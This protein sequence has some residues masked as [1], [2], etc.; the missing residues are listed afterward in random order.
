MKRYILLL[1]PF[2]IFGQTHPNLQIHFQPGEPIYVYETASPGASPV[3]YSA[4]VQNVAIINTSDEPRIIT[5][6]EFIAYGN[7]HP[8][9][10]K[11]VDASVLRQHAQRL[12]QYEQAGVLELLEFQLQRG[13]YFKKE[14]TL[15][16]SD[17]LAPKQVLILQHQ[18]FLFDQLPDQLQLKVTSR[19]SNAKTFEDVASVGIV[20]HQSDNTY[21]FPV[22]GQ[23]LVA[24]GPSF[25]GHHRWAGIQE[26]AFDLIQLGDGTRSFKN[27]GNQLSDYHCYGLPVRAVADG[28]VVKV[29]DSEAESTIMLKRSDE[30]EN[31]HLQRVM[32]HQGQLLEKGM[33][34]ILGNH[35]IIQHGSGEYSVYA[36]L[37]P[38]SIT[39]SVGDMPKS[40]ENLGAIGNSGNSTE[41]HLHFHLSDSPEVTYSRSLPIRF[42]GI[43]LI[44]DDTGF[45]TH[46]HSGQIVRAE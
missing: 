12:N 21:V 30:S 10:T 9:Q 19:D 35:V 28:E 2:S 17:T 25:S 20:N 32:A 40:G 42:K 22:T 1:I 23:W 34:A 7:E 38:G 24:A 33:D 44:P 36:H 11:H 26:F 29:I 37:K 45:I 31:E 5:S 3:L 14:M 43:A 13:S 41:P 6:A 16:S 8:I 46:L 39:V 4:L 15:A 27:E 18:P